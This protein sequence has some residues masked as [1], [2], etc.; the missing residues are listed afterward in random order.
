MKILK[1]WTAKKY[2][3]NKQ[4]NKQNK[5][6]KGKNKNKQTIHINIYQ[7]RMD[8]NGKNG[9]EFVASQTLRLIER[10]LE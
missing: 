9:I 1:N 5:Q 7:M 4:I 3:Y 10:K 2:T 8:M 6:N